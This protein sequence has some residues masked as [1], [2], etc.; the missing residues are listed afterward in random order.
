VGGGSAGIMQTG[1]GLLR[2]SST[3]GTGGSANFVIATGEH[4]LAFLGALLS[5]L[6][7]WLMA[8]VFAIVLFFVG[9]TV[10]KGW[11]SKV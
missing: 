5:I 11:F 10:Y 6:L 4:I 9:K 2:L 3:V 1:T 8:F 7:P